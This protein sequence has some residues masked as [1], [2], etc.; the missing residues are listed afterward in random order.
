MIEF[1][2]VNGEKKILDENGH[3]N[4]AFNADCM[5]FLRNCPDNAFSLCVCD[6]P[7]GAGFTETGG[8]KGWFTKYHQST[9]C[10]QFR[11][12]ERENKGRY[13]RFGNPGSIFEK[14]KR[15]DSRLDSIAGR[16][17]TDTSNCTQTENQTPKKLSRGTLPQERNILKSCSASHAIRSFGA[18]IILIY[19]RPAVF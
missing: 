11:N 4:I 7:Y 5:E 1:L 6:P 18:A 12:V 3:Y 16:G 17:M 19:L 9:D 2:D 15:E 14:Y 8:C 13:N 10:S